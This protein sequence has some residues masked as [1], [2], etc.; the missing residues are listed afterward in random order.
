M[1]NVKD[2]ALNEYRKITDRQMQ[3]SE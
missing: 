1:C 3:M 2:I